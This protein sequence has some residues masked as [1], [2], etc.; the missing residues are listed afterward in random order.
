MG[1]GPASTARQLFR[2]ALVV[3]PLGLTM[4]L[5]MSLLAGQAGAQWAIAAVLTL[6]L[7]LIGLAHV[8]SSA[9]SGSF[10]HVRP[11]VERCA[12]PVLFW[13]C[14]CLEAALSTILA[15]IGLWAIAQLL[16]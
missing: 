11:A 14:I 5:V 7:A 13:A 4:Y 2:T 8:V 9:R 6:P 16:S 1:D 12:S 15:L 3:L 10:I